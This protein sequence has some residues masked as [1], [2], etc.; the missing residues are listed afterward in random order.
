MKK[1]I[2]STLLMAATTLSASAQQVAEKLNRAPVAVKASTGVLVSWRHLSTDPAGLT[3][4]VYRNGTLVASSIADK[5]NYHDKTGKANDTY[6]IKASNGETSTTTAWKS[7]FKS[8]EIERPAGGTIEAWRPY[9]NKT[10][11]ATQ[12]MD[13]YYTPN[14]MSVADLDGDGEYELILKWDPSTSQ[15]NSINSG[16]TGNVFIDAYK[17]DG[18]RLWRIDL[19]KNIRAGAHYTQFLAYDFD[20]DGKAELICK[21]SAGSLDGKGVYVSEAATDAT[22]MGSTNNEA[23][24]RKKTEG[25]ILSGPEFLTVFNGETGA[26]MHTINYC[27][28]R[29]LNIKG[30]ATSYSASWG[31]SYG[32][33]GERFNACVAYLDGLGKLPTAIMQRGYYSQAF[34][35]AV[36]WN[37]TELSTRWIHYG[38]TK[39]SWRVYDANGT[40]TKSGSGKSSYGQGVHGISV[41]DVNGDGFDEIVMGSATIAHDGTLLCSTGKGHGDA[42]HLSDLVPSRPGLEVMMPHE[43]SPYGYDVH[44]AATG[45]LIVSATSSGDNGRGLAGDFIPGNCASEFWSSADN[46]IYSCEDGSVKLGSKPDTNF[47]IYWNGTAYDQTFDGRSSST[48]YSP[49]IRYYNNGK[50]SDFISFSGYG[51]PQCCNSTKSTPCLQADFL[52][53]WRE[54][55]IMWAHESPTSPTCRLLIYST[56]EP[57][58]YKVPCLMEDHVYRMGVAWQN[59]S[60]N[61]PPH[62]GYSLPLALGL[63]EIKEPEPVDPTI[64]TE[65]VGKPA[66]DK[67][68]FSGT[69]YTAGENQEYTAS[70]SGEYVKVRTGNADNTI[71]YTI[72]PGY[73]V[74]GVKIEGY[75]NNTSTTADRS[76]YMTGVYADDSAT[77]LISKTVTMPGGTAGKVPAV[78]DLKNFEATQSIKLTFDNK[79]IVTSDV[80]ANGKNKQIFLKVTFTYKEATTGISNVTSSTTSHTTVYNLNGQHVNTLQPGKVY[81]ING[82]KY[83]K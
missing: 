56:P 74:T 15:D 65:V 40:I 69:C 72:N 30:G 73:V 44:D 29:G 81:I 66:S 75:S 6:E 19:G 59:S 39:T 22:I 58:T 68:S 55:I 2:I 46:N 47:R 14:D 45:E 70:Y 80:D 54:E 23:D 35:W 13:Y 42:I 24:Y 36:D 25:T 48:G 9:A 83:I 5:T 64:M 31:D 57:T 76:I 41:G 17:Q 7:I 32:N 79:N 61:Q 16:I 77:S 71:T 26:A 82:K 34:F 11:G 33:R 3:F 67:A 43:E 60:Y 28:N 10:Y 4:D 49:R 62:L 63:E 20:G 21:T 8:L 51:S 50:I 38:N 27:P 1:L 52:G 18:T 12:A 78:T 37:G 53:D